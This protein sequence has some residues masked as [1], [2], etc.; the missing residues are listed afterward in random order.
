MPQFRL[1]PRCFQHCFWHWLLCL[2]VVTSVLGF[3]AQHS[4]AQNISHVSPVHVGVILP[5]QG[6]LAAWGQGQL[7][8]FERLR[9]RL[10]REGLY[11]IPVSITIVDDHSDSRRAASLAEELFR[12]Q[13]VH[14]LV[15][16]HDPASTRA[17]ANI[18]ARGVIS[19]AFAAIP[20]IAATSRAWMVSLSPDE[21]RIVQR[22]VLDIAAQGGQSLALMASQSPMGDDAAAALAQLLVPGGVRLVSTQRY[23]RDIAVLTPEALLVATQQ[24]SAV[25]VWDDA[26]TSLRALDAL[27]RRGYSGAV[28]VHPSLDMRS[29]PASAQE[30]L[31]GSLTVSSALERP[32]R[33]SSSYNLPHSQSSHWHS[34]VQLSLANGQ[35]ADL[36]AWVEDIE[37]VLR[38]AVNRAFAFG[39]AL[40]DPIRLRFALRDALLSSHI[41]G[42]SAN[43]SSASNSLTIDPNSLRI[44]QWREGR[45]V[46]LR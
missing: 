26:E 8:A 21:Q 12:D 24:P 5:L 7:P 27:R 11:G 43:F 30:V 23:P 13:E 2:G 36:E 33:A 39:V 17:V 42:R 4:Y 3:S 15:C 44:V 40:Q 9:T 10:E 32:L 25:L 41:E 22:I 14:M 35:Q 46:T 31:E 38:S 6:R 28:Y 20:D 45:L 16:C 37:L 1:F 29:L 19:L 34:D 18:A